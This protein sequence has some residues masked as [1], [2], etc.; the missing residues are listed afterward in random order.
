MHTFIMVKFRLPLYVAP[1]LTICVHVCVC[2]CMDIM[3]ALAKNHCARP[4]FL[5]LL[6][7]THIVHLTRLVRGVKQEIFEHRLLML[8]SRIDIACR[9]LK[10]TMDLKHLWQNPS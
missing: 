2:V 6:N 5:P 10:K 9:N 7:R 8:I 3:S 1:L 4:I